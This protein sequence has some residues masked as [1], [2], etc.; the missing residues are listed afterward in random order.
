M[1]TS[2]RAELVWLL[3]EAEGTIYGLSGERLYLLADLGMSQCSP[4]RPEGGC[5]EDGG[6]RTSVHAV[7]LILRQKGK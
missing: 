7:A 6:L 4:E 1:L 5:W 2:D 3:Y